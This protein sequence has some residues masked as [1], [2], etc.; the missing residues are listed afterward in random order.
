MNL[1]SRIKWIREQKGLSQAEF[2]DALNLKRNSITLI[3]GGKRNPSDR[4]I[5][6]ICKAFNVSE[7][8][9]RTGNGE[10]FIE[11]P[12]SVL[13][14]L[15]EE[16]H[17]DDFASNLILQYLKLNSDQRQTVQDF[18]YKVVFNGS[19][20]STPSGEL[21]RDPEPESFEKIFPAVDADNQRKSS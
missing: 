11:T 17:L 20:V 8:W 9:L 7:S 5:L 18:F 21:P 4:T 14:Q 19:T 15:Q 3:E 13:D 6:D 2:A 16:Y 12:S 10:P 1:N